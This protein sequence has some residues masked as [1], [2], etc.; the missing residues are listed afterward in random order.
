MFENTNSVLKLNK[1]LLYFDE[2]TKLN[3]RKYFLLKVNDYLDRNNPNNKGYII[4]FSL[5]WRLLTKLL[6]I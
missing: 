6:D 4:V 5:K 2:I 3:N 1:E